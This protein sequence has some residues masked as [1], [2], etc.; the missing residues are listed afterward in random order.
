MMIQR[1]NSDNDQADDDDNDIGG[2]GVD[3][4]NVGSGWSPLYYVS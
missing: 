3:F 4:M 1:K 2:G